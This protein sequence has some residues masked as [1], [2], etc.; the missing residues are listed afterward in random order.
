MQTRVEGSLV[1][2]TPNAWGYS[3]IAREVEEGSGTESEQTTVTGE[4]ISS[5]F[6]ILCIF[7]G[8]Q[9]MTFHL[10]NYAGEYI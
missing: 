5:L 10:R 2:V 6:L 8:A 3:Y 9:D 1:G 4:S 7:H